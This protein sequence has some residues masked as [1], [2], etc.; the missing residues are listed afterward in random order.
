MFN[1]KFDE[2]KEVKYIKERTDFKSLIMKNT[3]KK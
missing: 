2:L 1:S 3:L